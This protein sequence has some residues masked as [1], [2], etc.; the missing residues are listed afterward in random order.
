MTTA[1]ADHTP[2]RWQR[3]RRIAGEARKARAKRP[4]MIAAIVIAALYNIVG[5]L[6]V[7]STLAGMRAAGAVEANPL[8]R[9]FMDTLDNGWVVAKL[10]LQLIVSAMIV[11]FPHRVVLGMFGAA[12]ALTGWAVFNNLQ[13]AGLV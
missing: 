6:D 2:T 12:V 7:I 13:I 3:W 5:I 11:W 4:L 1:T 9:M 8:I 10:S